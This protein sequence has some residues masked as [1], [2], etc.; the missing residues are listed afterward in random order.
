MTIS[1]HLA[2]A[3]VDDVI[4]DDGLQELSRA[5]ALVSEALAIAD[6]QELPPE[7]GARLEESI[8][9][10]EQELTDRELAKKIALAF[11]R[12]DQGGQC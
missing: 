6:A 3:A 2:A 5:L 11:S 9:R 10:L 4:A 8:D 7:I 1:K 12:P